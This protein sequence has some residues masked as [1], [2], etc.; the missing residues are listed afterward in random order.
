MYVVVDRAEARRGM[1]REAELLA[2]LVER[3]RRGRG[4][5]A[6]SPRTWS[7]SR[8][9]AVR[10]ER[11]PRRPEPA[12][13]AAARSSTRCS[14]T[15]RAGAAWWWAAGPVAHREGREARS[16]T[17][18]W[19][20]WSAP[21][22][23]PS[24]PRSSSPARVAE[25]HRRART[26]PRTSTAAS[27]S[28]PPPTWT[29]STGWCGRTPRPGTC[30]ATSSTCPPLCNFIVPSIVR[31]GE[32]AAGRLHRGG[33]PGGGQAHPPRSSRRRYGPEWEALV[34]LLRDLRDELKVRYPDMPSRR[35]AVERLMETDVVR[36]ARRG[37]RR[38]RA[39]DLAR[40]WCSTIGVPV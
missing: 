24:W 11:Q 26:G 40:A 32:L 19:C 37:R 30:S 31:R 39:R 3:S 35:D 2:L 10:H 23:R 4:D 25:F 17:A 1:A 14:S 6:R 38:E 16:T 15:S 7:A 18:P 12:A 28:S 8:R 21:R 9:S 27:W 29:R 22:S 20:A 34:A 33:Q 5:A 13:R 36:A